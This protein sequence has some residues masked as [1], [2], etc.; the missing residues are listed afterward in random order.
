M[1]QAKNRG[2]FEQRK[3]EAI[4]AKREQAALDSWLKSRRPSRKSRLSR[5]VLM[6]SAILACHQI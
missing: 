2:S 4:Q 6:T 1:G 5:M 3:A